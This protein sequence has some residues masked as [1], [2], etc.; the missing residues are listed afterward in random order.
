MKKRILAALVASAAVLSLAGCNTDNNS[1]S[2]AN[3]SNNSSSSNSSSSG[4][5]TGDNSG[6]STPDDDNFVVDKNKPQLIDT[7]VKLSESEGKV[8]TIYAWNDEWKKMF[9]KYYKVPDGITVNWVITPSA[10]GAYQQKLDDALLNQD[11]AAAD[12]KIDI[13]LAEA[14]YIL[15]YV[16]SD[17]TK[18]VADIGFSNASTIYNYTADACTDSN[19][20]QKGMSFQCCP[21]GLIYRR[22]IAK[23]VIGS[24]DPA[25]VQEALSSW[26]KF[27]EV[28][29]KAKDMGYYMTPSFAE[30]YRTFSNNVSS[31]WVDAD[32]NVSVDPQIKA[33]IKQTK[34]YMDKGY[35]LEAGIWDDEKNS[36]MFKE[37]KAMCFFGPAWYY[38]FSMGNVK[39]QKKDADGNVIEDSPY[40]ERNTVGDWG[41]CVGP[42][43]YFWGGTWLLAG[44]QTDNPEL[45]ADIMNAFQSNEKILKQ[46]VEIDS[47]F[48]NNSAVNDSYTSNPDFGN[49]I[50]GGQNDWA[51]FAEG[52]KNIELKYATGYDQLL[53]EKLQDNLKDYFKGTV[54]LDT[55]WGNY[56][57]TINEAYAELKLPEKL[58]LD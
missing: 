17:Y 1:G 53:N 58:T 25:A 45:V 15:K 30:T 9:E 35:T 26:D 36:H 8:L 10:D 33:W 19:G 39:D 7:G 11:K 56:V 52:A 46:M 4:D 29:S 16:D 43:S 24:D 5:S 20:V 23:E 3:N 57:K 2:G 37:G 21:A 48:V 31:A 22:S 34:D 28:A 51:I 49:E 38:N 13:F 50:L 47:Q 18:N 6:A 32:G 42:Q 54:D 44:A 12:D 14:D 55:A 41:L 40:G 27:D